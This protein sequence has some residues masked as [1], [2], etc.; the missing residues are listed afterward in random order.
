MYS[1]WAVSGRDLLET[2]AHRGDGGQRNG[3]WK[4]T[5]FAHV[6]ICFRNSP[7]A[8]KRIEP[9]CYT[10][11]P[12]SLLGLGSSMPHVTRSPRC[13]TTACRVNNR[14][15]H[16]CIYTH[17]LLQ[18]R[19]Q[20]FTTTER[21]PP[22]LEECL[23]GNIQEKNPAEN[24]QLGVQFVVLVSDVVNK[25]FESPSSSPGRLHVRG[26]RSC[27]A[28]PTQPVSFSGEIRFRGRF[29]GRTSEVSQRPV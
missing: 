18:L 27:W 23:N 10:S 19:E 13:L 5:R 28:L 2:V 4:C 7:P 29:A 14:E 16:A 11:E 15:R 17:N 3:F 1:S 26:R 21:W 25:T 12:Q 8:A 24:L 6:T 20:G 22:T 9:M